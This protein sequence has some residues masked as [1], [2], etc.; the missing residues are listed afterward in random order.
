MDWDPSVL[1]TIPKKGNLKVNKNWRGIQMNEFLNAWYDWIPG[2]WI[3][4][5][6]NVDEFQTAYQKRKG[7]NTQII[8]LRTITDSARKQ[9][10]HFI[11]YIDLEKAFFRVRRAT[12]LKVLIRSGMGTRT[13][14]AIKSLYSNIFVNKIGTFRSTCGIH[15]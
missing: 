13:V 15:Q 11:S 5:W 6:M 10:T 14:Y 9:N 12:M 3:K 8:T 4:R 1:F 2:N 7:Y